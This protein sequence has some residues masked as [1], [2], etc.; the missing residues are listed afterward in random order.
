[1]IVLISLLA[2]IKDNRVALVRCTDKAIG[3]KIEIEA[4]GVFIFIG[5]EPTTGFLETSGVAIDEFGFVK[6][7]NNL[8]TTVPGIFAAGDVRS[9]STAQIASATGEGA[10]A[11][12]RIREY[13]HEL[14]K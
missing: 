3:K 11:A 9:G 4:E 5:L 6:T 8:E 10:T 14:H 1:M 2:S 12:L 13:L 7:N